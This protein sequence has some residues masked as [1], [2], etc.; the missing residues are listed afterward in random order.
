MEA[1]KQTDE[2]VII[3]ALVPKEVADRID[4]AARNGYISRSDVIRHMLRWALSQ[5][6]FTAEAFAREG[7]P[8]YFDDVEE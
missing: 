6:R 7:L 2:K 1:T 5:T 4:A 3:S 8:P